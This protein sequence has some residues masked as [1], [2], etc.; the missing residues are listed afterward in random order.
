MYNIHTLHIQLSICTLSQLHS[1]ILVVFSLIAIAVCL[2]EFLCLQLCQRQTRVPPVTA[3][4]MKI[5]VSITTITN[6]QVPRH[7]TQ[8]IKNPVILL[9]TNLPKRWVQALN[10]LQSFRI[11]REKEFAAPEIGLKRDAQ[12]LKISYL[13]HFN[14]GHTCKYNSCSCPQVLSFYGWVQWVQLTSQKTWEIH[15]VLCHQFMV[16]LSHDFLQIA[17]NPSFYPDERNTALSNTQC[18]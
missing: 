1:T 6:D 15:Q 8:K 7:L 14:I 3:T 4:A 9:I 18:G 16:C 5:P 13:S 2:N 12:R 11:V 10:L 17:C